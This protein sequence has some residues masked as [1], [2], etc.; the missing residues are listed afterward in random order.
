MLRPTSRR[1][2][3]KI[4]AAHAAFPA[5]ARTRPQ[6]R[7]D[8][9]RR[10]ATEILA[11]RDELG[12]FL[13]HEEG[14]TLL[15]QLTTS[16]APPGSSV[17]FVSKTSR[18]WD[19]FASV[20]QPADLVPGSAHSLAEILLR[21]GVPKGVFNLV[22]GRGSLVG[23]ATLDHMQADAITFTGSVAAGRQVAAPCA[24]GGAQVPARNGR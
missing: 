20:C 8:I 19:K 14:K 15:E 3:P 10:A 13:A 17:L 9:L 12:R 22:I 5:L 7:H 24:G 6:E 11:R 23:R 1:L 18:I 4:K 2:T 16:A 21:T